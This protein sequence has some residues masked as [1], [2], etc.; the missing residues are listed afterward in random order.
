MKIF[1][2]IASKRKFDKEIITFKEHVIFDESTRASSN[3]HTTKMKKRM[4]II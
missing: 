1:K 3:S 4:K 2:L